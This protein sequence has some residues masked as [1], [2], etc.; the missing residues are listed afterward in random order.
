MCAARCRYSLL[1]RSFFRGRRLV[2]V[3]VGVEF[4]VG[5]RRRAA[6]QWTRKQAAQGR[7]MD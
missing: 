3:G 1:L 5:R 7:L 2:T 6:V 4:R